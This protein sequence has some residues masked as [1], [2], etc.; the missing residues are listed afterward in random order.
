V[1]VHTRKSQ[2]QVYVIPNPVAINNFE[3][4]VLQKYDSH[5]NIEWTNIFTNNMTVKM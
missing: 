5:R 4:V 3:V 1:S 2:D